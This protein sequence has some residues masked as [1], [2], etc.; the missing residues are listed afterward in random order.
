MAICLIL[1]RVGILVSCCGQ[2]YSSIQRIMEILPEINI[3]LFSFVTDLP[4]NGRDYLEQ[5]TWTFLFKKIKCK[6]DWNSLHESPSNI[7]TE[8]L[9]RLYWNDGLETQDGKIHPFMHLGVPF[10]YVLWRSRMDFSIKH[11]YSSLQYST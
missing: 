11:S 9:N 5:R 2:V 4:A 6:V 10:I 1:K 3:K 7:S 8:D